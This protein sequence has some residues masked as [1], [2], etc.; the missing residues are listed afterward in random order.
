MTL[1]DS[2]YI[3]KTFWLLY[4]VC[5][6]LWIFVSFGHT[7]AVISFLE[8]NA[9][10]DGSLGQP[11]TLYIFAITLCFLPL[12][13][14][15]SQFPNYYRDFLR[16]DWILERTEVF[17][18]IFLL[19]FHFISIF[20]SD[21]REFYAEDALLENMTAVFAFLSGLLLFYSLRT[22]QERQLRIF[23]SF[24]AVLFL[25][26]AMEEISWGQRIFSIETPET[27]KELN[28]QDEFNL[29]N[30]FNPLFFAFYIIFNLVVASYFLFMDKIEKYLPSE[31]RVFLKP[32]NSR[33]FAFVFLVLTAHCIIWKSELT[34]EIVS[35]LMLF[36]STRFLYSR[37]KTAPQ[38]SYLR[39]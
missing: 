7:Q 13:L 33:F 23:I 20:V 37:H 15:I 18:I 34:E 12:A 32:R 5:L 8:Q 29:H 2:K 31:I 11:A 4:S 27:I 16:S 24:T 26:F 22:L 6:L 39:S 14:L 30:L 28:Y 19:G 38:Q 35:V 21:L 1:P 17:F 25:L 9:S 36:A 3:Q 10:S